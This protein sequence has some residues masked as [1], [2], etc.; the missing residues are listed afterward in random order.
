MA[1]PTNPFT[2]RPQRFRAKGASASL[3]KKRFTCWAKD[4]IATEGEEPTLSPT[5]VACP[6]RGEIGKGPSRATAWFVV[7][8][9]IPD[10]ES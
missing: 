4:G 3:R 5:V 7:V 6:A 10:R 9:R 2:D 1:S 8:E